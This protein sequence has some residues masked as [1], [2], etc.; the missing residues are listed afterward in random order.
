MVLKKSDFTVF[1]IN[2]KDKANNILEIANE[3]NIGL[4]SIV[5]IDDNPFERAL[6]R[7]ALPEVF[8]PDWPKNPMLYAS[9][10]LSMSCFDVAYLSNEDMVRNQMYKVEEKRSALKTQ[11]T[12][13]DDWINSLEMKIIIEKVGISNIVRVGQLFNKTNQ[14]NLST[15]RVSES[16]LYG[17]C[18]QVS[19]SFFCIKVEDKFGDYGLTGIIGLH[20]NKNTLFITDFILSCRV[21]GRKVEET[22]LNFIFSKAESLGLRLVKA[23]YLPTSKNKPCLDFFRKQQFIETNYVFEMDVSD[24]SKTSFGIKVESNTFK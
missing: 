21:M 19:N 15:R 13:L 23:E 17:L 24:Y 12:S 6:V 1:R 20:N 3:L 14:M 22:M 11:M 16:E 4:Q 9:S 2:W 10:L 18:E 7:D 8:V 5:F